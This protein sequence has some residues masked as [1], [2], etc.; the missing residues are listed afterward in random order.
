VAAFERRREEAAKK[1]AFHLFYLW[2]TALAL[3]RHILSGRYRLWRRS[4]GETSPVCGGRFS[5]R[6]N[7][8]G[9][10]VTI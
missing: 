2:W 5:L 9:H 1:A 8:F 7:F 6:R 4:A 3:H 10:A